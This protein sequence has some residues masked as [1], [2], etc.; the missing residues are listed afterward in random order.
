MS[1]I[2]DLEDLYPRLVGSLSTGTAPKSNDNA[3]GYAATVDPR[4]APVRLEVSDVVAEIET[5]VPMLTR[6]LCE[7]TGLL[8]CYPPARDATRGRDWLDPRVMAGLHTL[9]HHWFTLEDHFPGFAEALEE[10]LVRLATK[11]RQIVG[12]APRPA[13]PLVAR[14]PE[15]SAS[16]LFRVETAQGMVAACSA[17]K[18]RWTEAEWADVHRQRVHVE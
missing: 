1:A 6:Y 16:A 15:C 5:D 3:A 14:C 12:E 8:E 10:R 4:K 13:V 7:A 9:H 17:C 11:A 18:A 2:T